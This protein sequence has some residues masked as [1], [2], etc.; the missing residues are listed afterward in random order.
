[1]SELSLRDVSKLGKLGERLNLKLNSKS[2]SHI[3]GDYHSKFRGEGLDFDSVRKYFPGDDI[4]NID[5]KVTA[6]TG[7][8]HI[9][10]FNE[11]RSREVYFVIDISKDLVFATQGYLKAE[12]A[13]FSASIIAFAALSNKDKVGAYIFS[14]LLKNNYFLKAKNSQ[15]NVL[16]LLDSS[17]KILKQANKETTKESNSSLLKHL[18]KLQKTI[19]KNSIIILLTHIPE[20][21]TDIEDALSKLSHKRHI[22]LLNIIDPSDMSLPLM[23]DINLANNDD[24][25]NITITKEIQKRYEDNYKLRNEQ[26]KTFCQKRKINYQNILTNKPIFSQIQNLMHKK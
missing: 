1:M 24:K 14:D 19:G 20:L 13:I 21:T 4:R 23:S 7:K 16:Q 5:W 10:L 6:R 22:E 2:F 18:F 3:K 25:V 9:K 12:Q 26:L 11:D 8:P 15:S 17:L